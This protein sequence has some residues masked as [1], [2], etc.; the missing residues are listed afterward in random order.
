MA[1]PSRPRY[2][3]WTWESGASA[4]GVGGQ[5]SFVLDT[6]GAFPDLPAMGIHG[7]YT[8][9]R[10]H[11]KIWAVSDAGAEQNNPDGF[12]WGITV[13]GDDSVGGGT[14]PEPR[15]DAADWM[16][17]G[18]VAVSLQG[19]FSA[20]VHPLSEAVIDNKSMRKV[21]ENHQAL[22]LVMDALAL[23]SNSISVSTAGRF[24][25]SHGQ[26]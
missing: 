26:R 23:N 4:L 1:A 11:G 3:W 7:D 6:V 16:A 9:R 24:L 22:V 15:L 21:N 17:Y 2:T 5:L 12:V 18:E 8:V 19:G 10:I 25:V 14:F 13:M 20:G